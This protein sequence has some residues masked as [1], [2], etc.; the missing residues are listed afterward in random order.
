MD[1]ATTDLTQCLICDWH[2]ENDKLR[3]RIKELEVE[4]KQLLELSENLNEHPEGY[5]GPCLC[6]L[7]KSYG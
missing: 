6:Q 5:N 4:N 1:E 3:E 2:I 7:C